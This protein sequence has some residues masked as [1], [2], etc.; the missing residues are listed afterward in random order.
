MVLGKAIVEN[1]AT[2]QVLLSLLRY[3][4]VSRMKKS[5]L[6]VINEFIDSGVQA[7]YMQPIFPSTS[8][9][10]HISL[11]TGLYAESHGILGNKFY[12]AARNSTYE[13]NYKH[14]EWWTDAIPFWIT[15]QQAGRPARTSFAWIQ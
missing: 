9:A 3:D 4:Y 6:P 7:Q 14:D 15:A 8:C 10:A 2:K 1:V 13:K 12:S 11:V 5:E